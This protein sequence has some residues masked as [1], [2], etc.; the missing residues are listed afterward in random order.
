MARDRSSR[1][2]DHRRLELTVTDALSLDIIV[3]IQANIVLERILFRVIRKYLLQRT[4]RVIIKETLLRE[5]HHHSDPASPEKLSN[6]IQKRSGYSNSLRKA[7][8]P[9][10]GS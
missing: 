2:F 7:A 4:R 8:M 3:T 9:K 10:L 6:K 1:G 5:R